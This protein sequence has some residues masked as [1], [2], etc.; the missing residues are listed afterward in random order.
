MTVPRRPSR[1]DDTRAA[2]ALAGIFLLIGIVLI[3]LGAPIPMA[4]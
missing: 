4:K 1:Q 3:V 2:L